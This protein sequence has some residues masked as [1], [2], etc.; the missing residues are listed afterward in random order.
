MNTRTAPLQAAETPDNGA[1]TPAQ[2]AALVASLRAS[3]P[4]V[5]AHRGRTFVIHIP[6]EAAASPAFAD[7]VYDIAL[8]ASLVGGML[9]TASLF[10][11]MQVLCAHTRAAQVY[12]LERARFLDEHTYHS[13]LLVGQLYILQRQLGRAAVL[14]Q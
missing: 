2:N 7:L 10:R 4:Y 11:R 5:H 1:D 12:M 8:L 3:A 9:V 14:L 6:G 13:N